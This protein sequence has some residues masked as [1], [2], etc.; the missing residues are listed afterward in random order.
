ML[1]GEGTGF[2]VAYAEVF[3]SEFVPRARRPKFGDEN[4]RNSFFK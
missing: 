1:S 2:R 4:K 3:G